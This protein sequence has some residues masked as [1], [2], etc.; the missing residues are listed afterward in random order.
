MGRSRDKPEGPQWT[1]LVERGGFRYLPLVANSIQPQNP[2]TV[3]PKTN[4]KA[5]PLQTLPTEEFKHKQQPV[6]SPRH[7]KKNRNLH[8]VLIVAVRIYA[9]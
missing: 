9:I 3:S 2:L 5:A 1:R 4:R 7:A 8:A 6:I